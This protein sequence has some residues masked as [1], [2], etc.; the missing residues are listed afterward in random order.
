MNKDQLQGVLAGL[1]ILKDHTVSGSDIIG[2]RIPEDT[3]DKFIFNEEELAALDKTIFA[4]E[5]C[6]VVAK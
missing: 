3:G 1:Q 4:V 5:D 2:G 6:I